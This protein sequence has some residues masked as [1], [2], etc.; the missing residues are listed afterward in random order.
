MR[1]VFL[2]KPGFSKTIE[3]MLIPKVDIKNDTPQK[4]SKSTANIIKNMALEL[5]VFL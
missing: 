1:N 5:L 4:G 3:P 2:G